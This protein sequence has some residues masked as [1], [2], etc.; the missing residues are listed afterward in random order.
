MAKFVRRILIIAVLAHGGRRLVA[1]G[2]P[3][4][5]P[6][7]S[8]DI[9]PAPFT[10]PAKD[11]QPVSQVIK[12]N[13]KGAPRKPN[14]IIIL[15][16]DL[17]YGDIEAYGTKAIRTPQLDRLAQ[18]GV[19]FTEFYASA[20]VCSPSRAG[21]LTG[22]YPV[23]TGVSYVIFASEISFEHRVNLA[24]S[25]VATRLGMSDFHD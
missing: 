18:E 19:R 9:D 1:G 10:N 21:L 2:R 7:L 23:R 12:P 3:R 6:G 20:N 17:G 15:A 5:E 13:G 11:A 16:D 8:A 25:R 4:V 24:L 14:L 22:R